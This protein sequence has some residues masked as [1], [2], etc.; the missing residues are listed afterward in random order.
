MSSSDINDC[1][2]MVRLRANDGEEFEVAESVAALSQ[3]LKFVVED[4]GGLGE[5]SVIP[6]LKVDGNTLAKIL[7]YCKVHAAA[8]GKSNAEKKEFDKK[9]VEVDQAELYDL[10]TAAD[11]LEIRDLLELMAQRVAD[12]IKG[13]TA[14]DIRKIFNIKNDFTPEEEEEILRQNAWAY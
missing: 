5:D 1:E 2:K 12:M 14:E 8:A 4:A 3:T 10:L 13:K 7:E 9:F 11:Y 6:L